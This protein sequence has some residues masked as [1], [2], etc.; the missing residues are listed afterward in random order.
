MVTIKRNVN[1]NNNINRANRNGTINNLFTGRNFYHPLS[2]INWR[3]FGRYGMIANNGKTFIGLALVFNTNNGK[4]R[5]IELMGA[6]RGYG[7]QLLNK[8]VA[9][10]KKNN[11]QNV[12]LMAAN[13]G[14]GKL[15]GFYKGSGFKVT[16]PLQIGMTPMRRTIRNAPKGLRAMQNNNL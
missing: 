7:Q 3:S 15:I 12:F 16:G 9:N 2:L 10:A 5:V 4:S 8:I 13:S 11:K 14:S 1:A 6:R